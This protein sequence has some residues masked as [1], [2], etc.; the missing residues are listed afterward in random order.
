VILH[1]LKPI[2]VETLGVGASEVV[3]TARFVEDLGMG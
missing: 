3:P 2:I 1:E